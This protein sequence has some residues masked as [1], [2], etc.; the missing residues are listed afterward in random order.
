MKGSSNQVIIGYIGIIIAIVLMIVSGSFWWL[1]AV[2][3]MYAFAHGASC[4]QWFDFPTLSLF[5]S[6]VGN[7]GNDS[8]IDGS[9]SSGADAGGDVSGF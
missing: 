2:Y 9:G 3:F 4:D 1:I 8:S 6:A 5:D 7:V